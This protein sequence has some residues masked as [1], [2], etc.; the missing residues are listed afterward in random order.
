MDH[1]GSLEP[2]VGGGL[3]AAVKRSRMIALGRKLLG[4]P[5]ASST[6]A[7]LMVENLSDEEM[8]RLAWEHGLAGD[9][10]YRGPIL[11]GGELACTA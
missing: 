10:A 6:M 5:G 3:P 4:Y 11:C 2:G 9:I 7:L 1:R 8:A